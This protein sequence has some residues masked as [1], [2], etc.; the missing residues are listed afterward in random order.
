MKQQPIFI[1]I[2]PKRWRD[3]FNPFWW[4]RARRIEILMNYIASTPEYQKESMKRLRDYYLYG[5][6]APPPPPY[7]YGQDIVEILKSDKEKV[8]E[9]LYDD[10]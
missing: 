6:G 3:F 10:D 1:K 9:L 2:R 5:Y 7:Y 8:G 4:R